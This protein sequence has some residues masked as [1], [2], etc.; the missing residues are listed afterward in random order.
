MDVERIGFFVIVQ[1]HMSFWQL[2]E[3][4]DGLEKMP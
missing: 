4:R 3:M 2:H 1:P